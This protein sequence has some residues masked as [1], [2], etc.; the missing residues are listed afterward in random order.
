[1]FVCLCNGVTDSQIKNAIKNK[2][3]ATIEDLIIK[4]NLGTDCGECLSEGID[5]LNIELKKLTHK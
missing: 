1:M 2:D 4:L 5:L 3:I